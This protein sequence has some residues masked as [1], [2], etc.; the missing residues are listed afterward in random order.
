MLIFGAL[1]DIEP[2]PEQYPEKR[3]LYSQLK[4]SACETNSC[5]PWWSPT[6]TMSQSCV[7]VLAWTSELAGE[8]DALS[9]YTH[10]RPPNHKALFFGIT[11]R[12]AHSIPCTQSNESDE[13]FLKDGNGDLPLLEST[14]SLWGF[15]L[16]VRLLFLAKLLRR[17]LARRL[18]VSIMVRFNEMR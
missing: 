7:S 1:R 2:D 5:N 14:A 18:D 4:I 16:F 9:G 6:K 15:T 11:P 10:T 13:L 12:M 17:V 3:T 8:F